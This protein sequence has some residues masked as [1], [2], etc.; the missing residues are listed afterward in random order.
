V[1]QAGALVTAVIC[2]AAPGTE[3]RIT[4]NGVVVAQ[5]VAGAG[6]C[7]SQNALGRPA[8][9]PVLA[10]MGPLGAALRGRLEAQANNGVARASFRVPTNLP[11]GNYLVCAEAPGKGSGCSPFRIA[12]GTSVLGTTFR[13][14]GGAPLFS[15]GNGNS[16]L[17]FTGFGLVRLLLLAG[18]LIA[19]GWFLVRRERL[20]S[21]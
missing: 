21:A 7:P 10:A 19:C 9:G 16:F 4:F 17:A 8:G 2:N 20:R 3:I 12:G 1:G 18:S 15:A 11:D 6:S 5:V 14:G 13:G